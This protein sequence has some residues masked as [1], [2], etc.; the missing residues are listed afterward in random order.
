MPGHKAIHGSANMYCRAPP[1]S[2]PPQLGSGGGTP[3]PRKLRDASIRIINGT[4]IENRM[5]MGAM[6]FGRMCWKIT[7]GVESPRAI[8]E[9]IYTFSLT[10]I[11][12]LRTILVLPMPFEIPRQKI[13]C[14]RPGLISEMMTINNSKLGML[15]SASTNLCS[16]RSNL[17]PI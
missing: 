16:I 13:T 6:M 4:F 1:L 17:P 9:F 2:I 10:P 12:R 14:H 3:R 8:A 5:M 11:T 15:I 7:L